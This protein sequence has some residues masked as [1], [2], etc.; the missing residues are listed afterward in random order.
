MRGMWL[1]PR[2]LDT[3][4]RIAPD[5]AEVAAWAGSKSLC[6]VY[7]GASPNALRSDEWRAYFQALKTAL[8]AA[9]M[10]A[11]FGLPEW[12]DGGVDHRHPHHR[13]AAEWTR[14]ALSIT[15]EDSG[16]LFQGVM[17][18]VEPEWR[19]AATSEQMRSWIA[20]HEQ[21]RA[22]AQT[23]PCCPGGTPAAEV[24]SCLTWNL[25]RQAL[26]GEP[27]DRALL[28]ATDGC[29]FMTYRNTVADICAVSAACLAS[30]NAVGKPVRIMVECADAGEG[31]RVDFSRASRQRLNEIT[32]DVLAMLSR[33]H[34]YLQGLDFHHYE[35]WRMLP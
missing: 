1:Y 28:R 33:D 6:R 27:L 14:A 20:M 24:W 13:A 22:E 3:P 5:P 12:A 18:N 17:L 7:V 11:T 35:A 21:A 15:G 34:P 30:S 26:D 16:R 29:A 23:L 19:L 2:E 32:W 10:F 9:E 8:G 4:Y 25:D 31:P